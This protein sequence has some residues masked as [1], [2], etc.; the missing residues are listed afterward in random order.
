MYDYV[1][2]GAGSAGCA[3]AARLAEDPKTRVAL[4]EAGGQNQNFLVKVPA[5]VVA[6]LPFSNPMNYGFKTVPQPGL[7][8]R[9]G[10]Q[11]RGKGLGGSSAINAMLYM[12]GNAWDYDHWASLGNTGWAYED[13]LPYFRKSEH[14]E[15]ID[16]EY[17]GQNGPLNVSMLRS[18]SPL[19][20]AFIDACAQNQ[21]PYNPDCNGAEQFGSHRYQ[22]THKDG[23]RWTAARAYLGDTP[24]LPNLDI[25]TKTTVSRVLFD[26]KKAT[27]IEIL[28]GRKTSVLTAKRE[29]II[30]GGAFGSPQILMMSGIGPA[31]H[32]RD[33]GID[34]LHDL[35][36]VG[37]NLQDHIDL[38]HTF[39]TRASSDTLGISLRGSLDIMKAFSHWRNGH[40]GLFNSTYAESGA[41]IRSRADLDIPDLQLVFVRAIVDDHAR[42]QH[43]GHGYSCHL[44]LLRPKSRGS[45]TLANKNP[46]SAP[47]IDPQFFAEQEDMDMMIR[48]AEI[49]RSILDSPAFDAHRG[50]ILY[51]YDPMNRDEIE[52]DIRNRADTQYHPVGTCAMGQ[53]DQSVV[54]ERLRVRGVDGLRVIDASVMPTLIGGNTNAP[55][56]MIAEKGADMIKQDNA[57]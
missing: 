1:I 2:A 20:D 46:K 10:Y 39:R 47:V 12:R 45:V 8:G 37:Q 44:T 9:Q 19:N 13:V 3:L 41:Y 36:G 35:P 52:Q 53:T 26:G 7:N 11:P 34:V 16:D 49:Q 6:M 23:E 48:G 15:F 27:G 14:N 40:K 17:H 21:I 57:A 33:K 56:I 42:K 51:P 18:P 31:G 24:S 30:C 4:I 5:A 43:L 28:R 54:D 29:V 32:L 22:V 38:V 50:D 55:T 25:I